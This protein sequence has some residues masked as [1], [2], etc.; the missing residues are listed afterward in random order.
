ML[1]IVRMPEESKKCVCDCWLF[2]EKAI[3]AKDEVL[4]LDTGR[5]NLIVWKNI[6]R[7]KCVYKC[8]LIRWSGCVYLTTIH[9]L[10]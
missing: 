1:R 7:Y 9:T 3:S 6:T 4:Q 10:S 8:D 5:Y 2:L